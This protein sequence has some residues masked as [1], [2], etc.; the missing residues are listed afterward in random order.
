MYRS[1]VYITVRAQN[2]TT[3]NQG[4]KAVSEYLNQCAMYK[5]IHN[6]LKTHLDYVAM[7]CD[8][9]TKETKRMSCL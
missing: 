7:V 5:N 9:N 8:R 6:S 3:L 4:V 1:R 2:G